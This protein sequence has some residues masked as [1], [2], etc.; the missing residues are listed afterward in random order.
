MKNKE[1][2]T[3]KKHLLKVSRKS[4]AVKERVKEEC[5]NEKKYKV[6]VFGRVC[7]FAAAVP[8]RVCYDDDGR[9]SISEQPTL[10]FFASPESRVSLWRRR[11]SF[12]LKF[13]EAFTVF[14]YCKLEV[15]YFVRR[16]SHYSRF[17]LFFTRARRF[18]VPFFIPS[19][20]LT[21]TPMFYSKARRSWLKLKAL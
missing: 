8:S 12:V 5:L 4:L 11:G 1:W 18:V 7:C 6:T 17:L 10:V 20:V 2:K 9:A 13:T 16:L 21:W 15:H 19:L 3:K 14:F